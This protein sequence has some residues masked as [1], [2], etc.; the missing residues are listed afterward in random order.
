[1]SEQLSDQ[2]SVVA[3][4][5]AAAPPPPAPTVPPVPQVQLTP[6]FETRLIGGL[7][8]SSAGKRLGAYLL[9]GVL[10]L[11]TLGIGWVIWSVIVWSK[12]QTPAKALMGMRCVRTD[13]GRSATWGTMA[14]RELVGKGVIGSVTFGI[15]TLVSCFMILG[16][17][18]Q[19]VWDKVAS[20]VVVDD[21][22]GRLAPA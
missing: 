3:G 12:G 18:R 14:L 9:D 11:V 8:V 20:T 16:A 4:T 13:T 1:M 21:P 15:T 2:S 5:E 10:L 22:D 19:G 6:G 7:P 17:A